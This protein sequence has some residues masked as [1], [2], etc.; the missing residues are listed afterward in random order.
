MGK[1]TNNHITRQILSRLKE[2]HWLFM[3]RRIFSR[4]RMLCR[5]LLRP[6]ISLALLPR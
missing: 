5:P 6:W 3:S 1:H 4:M 2:V